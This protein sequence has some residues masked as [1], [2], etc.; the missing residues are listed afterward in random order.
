MAF[1]SLTGG[2]DL[3]LGYEVGV[4]WQRHLEAVISGVKTMM[5]VKQDRDRR[6]LL[7]LLTNAARGTLKEKVQA[8]STRAVLISPLKSSAQSSGMFMFTELVVPLSRNSM[9]FLHRYPVSSQLLWHWQYGSV[10]PSAVSF[11][12]GPLFLPSLRPR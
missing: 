5:A 6:T 9:C 7:S 12:C 8:M 10:W 4:V 1:F 3:L 11:R 2:L